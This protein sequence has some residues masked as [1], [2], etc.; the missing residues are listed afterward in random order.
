MSQTDSQR[1][2]SRVGRTIRLLGTDDPYTRLLP[3][4]HGVI[5][6]FSNDINGAEKVHVKW[7]DGSNLALIS[8]HDRFHVLTERENFVRALTKH[9]SSTMSLVVA[10]E[11]INE[12]ETLRALVEATEWPF[13]M[14]LDEY[15]AEM[16]GVHEKLSEDLGV[17][18]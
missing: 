6:G 5:T 16:Q 17:M 12:D 10:W 7:E 18:Q 8:G 13:A 1:L 3:G 11:M 2:T 15:V 9:I 14:S 4:S